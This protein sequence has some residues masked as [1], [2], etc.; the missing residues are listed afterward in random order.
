MMGFLQAAT[1][2]GTTALF[3]PSSYIYAGQADFMHEK[4]KTAGY[5]KQILLP[6]DFGTCRVTIVAPQTIKNVGHASGSV[7]LLGFENMRKMRNSQI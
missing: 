4:V 1:Y 5:A 3:M 6:N 2:S 7:I